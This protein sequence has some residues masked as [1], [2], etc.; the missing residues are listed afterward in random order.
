MGGPKVI[1]RRRSTEEKLLAAMPVVEGFS[2]LAQE[3]PR[4]LL[5][6]D[7]AH[8]LLKP[9][10]L[11]ASMH[12]LSEPQSLTSLRVS[13]LPTRWSDPMHPTVL[14]ASCNQHG[15]PGRLLVFRI[16]HWCQHASPQMSVPSNRRY[17][18]PGGQCCC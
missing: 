12:Q 5:I 10:A 2:L 7:E 11:P 6:A 8:V 17:G 16:R 1:G 15:S 14:V 9:V 3:E 18:R 4:L 13:P